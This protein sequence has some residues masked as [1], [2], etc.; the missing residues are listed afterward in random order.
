MKKSQLRHIIRKIIQEQLGP[1][2]QPVSPIPTKTKTGIAPEKPP[3]KGPDMYFSKDTSPV[4]PTIEKFRGQI[5]N[6]NAIMQLGPCGGYNVNCGAG[7]DFPWELNDV[8]SFFLMLFPMFPAQSLGNLSMIPGVPG[9][10]DPIQTGI[11]TVASTAGNADSQSENS[12]C[13]SPLWALCA[14][15]FGQQILNTIINGIPQEYYSE[16]TFIDQN[17][18]WCEQ[19]PWN[20]NNPWD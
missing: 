18:D 11:D 12:C 4:R 1:N 8:E 17:L 7:W 15:D 20:M 14:P 3:L 6:I 9:Y 10:I 13:Q 16:F 19:S 5:N 2:R